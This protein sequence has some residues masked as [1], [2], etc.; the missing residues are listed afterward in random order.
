MDKNYNLPVDAEL[1]P[2]GCE[3]CSLS[4]FM[5]WMA[6]VFV[7]F[8]WGLYAAYRVLA[9][10]LGVTGLDD[11]FGFGLWITFDLAVIALGA[12][13]FFS[14]L[15]RYILN[16]D[17]LKNI[18]NL[19]VIIGFLCYSGAMLVLVL[20]IG[21]PLRAWFGYWHANVHSMLT[22]VIF[23]ITCYCLV[24]IIEYV[25]L[26][27][28]NRQLNKNKL[29]HAVAH[30][31]HVMMPLFAGIGAF[32]STFHQ[33]SLGGMYGVLFGRPYIYREGFFIWPWTFFLYV[34][35]AVGSGPVF[36]VLVCTLME[37]M[38]GRKLV[39]WEVK[40]LM[41][42]IAGTMLMVYLIFKFADTYAWAYD[43]LPRQGLTFDQMFTSGWIYG[44]WMLWAEL[45]Y[46][47][48]VPAI[49]L[50]VPALRNNPVLFY[51]AAILDCI[52]ITINRYVMTVQALAIP[53][54]PFD[55]WESYLPNWAEWG[56][57]VMIVAYAALVLSLSYRYLPI[58][59][60][61]AELN[62]K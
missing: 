44:K 19:A 8:G 28:E 35:S 34:L 5:M 29:V 6:F 36:T 38:T 57:S 15:L 21:Q 4:K 45:F 55:S 14:G 33:G 56:A 62:R 43:L 9:E 16:I 10:G 40:S 11:Y 59:P 3:R 54:M 1:F 25:P 47:G 41:G 50:I 2:E 39:S 42:K 12:G 22:E 24:L 61:E 27:L 20:D 17:P 48:L 13:A 32:L 7:F 26:I 18:I 30:N 51:S 53:V 60:Q 49:I 23:C 58:F 46:C 37:K 31:F 52:G